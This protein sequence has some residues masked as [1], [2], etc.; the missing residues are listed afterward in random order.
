MN[1]VFK[2]LPQGDNQ[3]LISNPSGMYVPTVSDT[4]ED[5]PH[6]QEWGPDVNKYL[7]RDIYWNKGNHKQ[8][9]LLNLTSKFWDLYRPFKVIPN[10]VYTITCD[11][12][13]GTSSNCCVWVLESSQWMLISGQCFDKN[14]NLSTDHF[15]TITLEFM[16]TTTETVHIHI[17]GHDK[18]LPLQSEGTVFIKDFKVIGIEKTVN[19]TS[20][21][22]MHG[23]FI[24]TSDKPSDIGIIKL[25]DIEKFPNDL[26]VYPVVITSVEFEYCRS[27]F[28]ISK[29]VIEL[30]NKD[31]LKLLLLCSFEPLYTDII[32]IHY[33]IAWIAH[34]VHL[35]K[36]DNIIIG[37]SDFSLP[38]KIE[39]Y[40]N[41]IEN[42]DY[43]ESKEIFINNDNNHTIIDKRINNT[44]K[45]PINFLDCNIYAYI[46]PKL[47]Q[48]VSD[49]N[50]LDIYS[51]NLNKPYLFL[52]LNNRVTWYRYGLYKYFSYK[53]LLKHSLHS[54]SNYIEIIGEDPI[55]ELQNFINCEK[56]FNVIQFMDYLSKNPNIENTRIA[57]DE[58][59]L[60]GAA[61]EQG[62]RVNL[63]WIS[64]TYFSV[65]T[66]T[67]PPRN[68]I[69]EKVYKLI[70]CCHPFILYGPKNHLKKLGDYGFK[71][72]PE[73]FDE[74][75]D[76]MEDNVNKI[77]F[78]GEQVNFYTTDEGKK[79]LEQV[80]PTI[81]KKLE[82]NRNHL[83]SLNIDDV[84]KSIE[85]LYKND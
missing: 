68:Q 63:N 66:E 46:T 73:L 1:F 44:L 52:Y 55:N 67:G 34:L 37:C 85:N 78:I 20:F 32:K 71:T 38:Q 79:K 24:C 31:K 8:E 56:S 81:L 74:S 22:P 54:W 50:W 75:Y 72:F 9:F 47:L 23:S 4:V 33:Q 36:L 58:A 77:E 64:N 51:K 2:Q 10:Q 62:I 18:F 60:K 19:F 25:D 40:H 30:V 27:L 53:N 11:I 35:K 14:N 82:F 49:I 29:K 7:G 80:I 12:K 17:G 6:F 15:T 69:T 70:Y 83:L 21:Q 26:N 59:N 76:L 61:F 13:L 43:L 39:Y 48:P 16:S 45:S 3:W 42:H 65:V 5:H 28:F 57:D 84:W 41:V